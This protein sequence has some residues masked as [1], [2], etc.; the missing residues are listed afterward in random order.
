MRVALALA[1]VTASAWLLPLVPPADAEC[2][3]RADASTPF[4]LDWAFIATVRSVSLVHDDEVEAAGEGDGYRWTAVFDIDRVI[5]G[6]A[7]DPLTWRGHTLGHLSCGMD[8]RGENLAIGDRLFMAGE[9]TS[10]RLLV[11]RREDGAWRFDPSLLRDSRP[12]DN[13][14]P[15][16]AR[17]THSTSELLALLA[18]MPDTATADAQTPVEAG[19]GAHVLGSILGILIAGSWYARRRWWAFQQ[20]S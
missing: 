7:E 15:A 3:P 12:A 2:F 1:V 9:A 4:D 14:Y 20:R 8:L 6:P 16:T 17:G 19:R 5:D 18:A 10:R 11:W 13:A